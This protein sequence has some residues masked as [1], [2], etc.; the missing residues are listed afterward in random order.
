M[1]IT[2]WGA[3]QS[4]TGS[5]HVLEVGGRRAL[6]DCGLFQGRREEA[7]TRNRYLPFSAP[8]LDA[9]V[10]SH[11][12]IDHSGNLPN[13]V[14]S[15]FRGPI[16]ATRA[17]CAL[18]DPMLRDSAHIH[19]RDVEFLNKSRSRRHK[20]PKQPIYTQADVARTLPRFSPHA[21]GTPFEVL[22]GLR[23][24]FRDAGHILG[25]ALTVLDAEEGGRRLRICF[26]GDL[27][28]AG[29][30][31]IR[32]PEAVEGVDVLIIESTYGDRTHGDAGRVAERLAAVL[33]PVFARR[34]KV[35][36]PAFAVGRT[37]E[38]VYVLDELFES[39][40]LPEVPVYIDSPLAVD[41]SLVFR[42][43]GECFDAET[44]AL[45]ETGGN[46]PFG[47]RHM[48]YVRDVEESKAL[49]NREGPLIVISAS[50][51]CEAGRVLHHLRNSIGDPR[52]LVLIV[53]FQAEN[54]LGRRLAER[55]DEVRIFGETFTRRA[56]VDS[57]DAF[58]AHADRG[59][60]LAWVR[61]LRPRPRRIF[62]VHG[63][64][65]P[66]LHLAAEL[67]R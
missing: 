36:I 6:L 33:A 49:N 52:N 15:G 19:E 13:L 29:L 56:Q 59:E 64:A 65:E 39:G 31:I 42:E 5:R 38:I 24:H 66:S 21:Y 58:S 18:C 53:G 26:T 14:K 16:H 41:V 57:I 9:V 63:E 3:V 12:H 20:P 35:I 23:T 48:H 27:G 11:A 34:G 55:R 62:V 10:L 2:F 40:R 43:H 37:Q 1:R 17:T 47:F 45:L 4:V 61:G 54:T 30:P 46:D 67:A 44:R 50:G 51:M 60:L 28:R 8:D 22:P 25:S 7:E 32:D